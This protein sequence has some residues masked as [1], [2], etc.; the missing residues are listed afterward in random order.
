MH[1]WTFLQLLTAGL[2]K[3]VWPFWGHQKLKGQCFERIC[4]QRASMILDKMF[5]IRPNQI[6]MIYWKKAAKIFS[7]NM[8][9]YGAA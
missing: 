2:F 8:N 5:I 4:L 9:V 6:F 1:T 7:A 3:Y